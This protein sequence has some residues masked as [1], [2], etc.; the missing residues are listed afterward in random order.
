M[1]KL[2][3]Y[4]FIFSL[5]VL[6]SCAEKVSEQPNV[7]LIMVD[8]LNDWTGYLGGH[9]QTLTP[10]IDSLAR[11]GIA[12][13]NA[14]ANSPLCGPS[15][16]SMLTGLRP[17]T[18]GIYF[19]IQDSSLVRQ[20][21]SGELKATLLPEHF[22]NHGYKTMAVG[23]IFHL[24]DKAGVFERYGGQCNFG[25]KPENRFEY[26]PKWFNKPPGTS[27][28]WGA[29]PAYDSLTYD[30]KIADWSIDRLQENHTSPFF[31]ATG[32]MRPHVPWYVPQEW[33]NK[34]LLDSIQTPSYLS[35]D[36]ED[37]PE[38]GRLITEWPAMPEMD[39][40]LQE[41]RWKEATR[42]YLA[43]VHFVDY[44]VGRV[45]QQL[46]KSQ[47]AD[48]TIVLLVSDHGYHLGE[49]GLFQKGTLW[50]RS[51]HIPMIW[52]G[53][54]ISKG[55]TQE[56]ASLLD[57]Y[58]TLSDLC[59]FERPDYLEGV[60]LTRILNGKEE[61]IDNHVVT[62]YGRKNHSV[63][64]QNWHYIKYN[65]GS[66]ELYDL[67]E[68]RN[69]WNNLILSSRGSD[70]KAELADF[71]PR[72]NAAKSADCYLSAIPYFNLNH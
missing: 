20:V 5:T 72:T 45:L 67:K 48:N 26:D 8:D 32:F 61:S 47:Y 22:Q 33:L 38:M 42:A 51:S 6:F 29:F 11:S 10:N 9:A 3:F 14:H 65:D 25:P 19:H 50:E 71:L 21:K 4:V 59:G 63:F 55:V 70:V 43:S 12:F 41:N 44:Q 57:I 28:D 36:W 53:K 35:Q 69:E 66:E 31:L 23:K 34:F 62:T 24:G 58:P 27:T 40:M 37:I 13:A 46:S 56:L 17:S 49:K 60:S 18:S 52:S 2:K 7:L 16:S 1:K 39:W 68:D 54:G 64:Y 15:R 30:E